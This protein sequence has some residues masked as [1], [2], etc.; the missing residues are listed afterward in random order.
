MNLNIL[1]P[2]FK[3]QK[4]TI[5]TLKYF[6]KLHFDI[7]KI[8]FLLYYKFFKTLLFRKIIFEKEKALQQNTKGL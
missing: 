8:L 5:F 2:P 3:Y 1:L 7:F 6:A 4:R